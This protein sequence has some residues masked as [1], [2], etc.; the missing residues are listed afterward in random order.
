MELTE[1]QLNKLIAT[2][3]NVQTMRGM[4]VKYFKDRLMGDLQRSKQYESIVDREV[5][6]VLKGLTG[7]QVEEQARLL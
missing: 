2:L 7:K 5:A 4:Q 6:A 3:K 1:E